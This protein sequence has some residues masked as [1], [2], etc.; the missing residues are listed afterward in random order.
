MSEFCSFGGQRFVVVFPCHSGV[1]RE[2]ELVFPAKLEPRFA[3]RVIAKLRTRMSFRKV[4]GMGSQFVRDDS[5]LD[6]LSIWQA[7]MFF[8]SHI[9]EHRRAEPTDHRRPD[10]RCNMVVAGCDVGR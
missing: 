3:K 6:V 10:G 8:R 7:E 1:E 9:T 2:V 5:L 4:G